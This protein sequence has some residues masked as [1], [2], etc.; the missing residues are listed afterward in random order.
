MLSLTTPNDQGEGEAPV[1]KAPELVRSHLVEYVDQLQKHYIETG[2][3]YL[4]TDGD[5]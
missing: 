4:E 1:N 2:L 3:N 5:K